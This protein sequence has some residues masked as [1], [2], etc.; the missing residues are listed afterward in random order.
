MGAVR[1]GSRDLRRTLERPIANH[2]HFNLT[3]LLRVA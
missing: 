2:Q 3:D 1:L